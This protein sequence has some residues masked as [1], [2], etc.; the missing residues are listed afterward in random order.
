MV[1]KETVMFV[2]TEE[3]KGPFSKNFLMNSKDT[4]TFTLM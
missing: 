1:T 4:Y 3:H 2:S